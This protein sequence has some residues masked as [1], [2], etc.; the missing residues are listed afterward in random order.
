M[1]S[2]DPDAGEEENVSAM[3][4][5]LGR[6][7]TSEITYAA[8]DSDF[9][10]FAITQ[11]DYL[12]LAEHQLFGTDRDIHVLLERLAQA[13]PQQEAE[14]ITIF[15]RRGRA[16]GRGP[17]DPGAVQDGLP[18]GG[19]YPF[20]RRPAGLLLYD[21]RGIISP[22]K[23]AAFGRPFL[24]IGV[25]MVNNFIAAELPP[26]FPDFKHR[27]AKPCTTLRPLA[28]GHRRGEMVH[29]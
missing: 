10:G 15:L 8:R 19:N 29:I 25:G 3:T 17:E 24:Y 26:F 5:A 13:A 11:G 9:D 16:G 28:Q 20:S 12:A 4:E 6:V 2:V 18:Q 23:R 27:G 7:S 22:H 21:F 14:F 1:L